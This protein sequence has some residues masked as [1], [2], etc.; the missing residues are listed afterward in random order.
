MSVIETTVS[1]SAIT[2]AERRRAE[3]FISSNE[4]SVLS[5][6]LERVLQASENG[7]DVSI[8]P[9]DA[10]LSPNK[11]AELLKMS[12]PHLLS[13]MDGGELPFHRVGTHRRIKM[14]DLREFMLAREAGAEI[15][16]NA[17]HGSAAPADRDVDFSE[18]EL[19][20]LDSL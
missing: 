8:L 20:E 12:R 18:G 14:A 7:T 19:A 4:G 5:I 6:L 16:A 11:A 9:T 15:L 3:E 1:A 17:L 2:E 13:F 10:E